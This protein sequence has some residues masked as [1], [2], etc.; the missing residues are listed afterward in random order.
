[1]W[2]LDLNRIIKIKLTVLSGS[3]VIGTIQFSSE[4]I[5]ILTKDNEF[6]GSVVL[7]TDVKHQDK[8]SG[9]IFIHLF[10]ERK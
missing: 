2:S 1:M 3:A 7:E 9:N 5:I 10:L 4:D 6:R 8:V